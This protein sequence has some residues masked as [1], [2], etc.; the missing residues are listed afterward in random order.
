MSVIAAYVYRNGQRVREASVSDDLPLEPG[1]FVWIGLFEPDEPEL[2]RLQERF[3]LHPLAV[4]DAL[5]AHQRPKV[6]VYGSELFVVARTAELENDSIVSGETHCF[7]GERYVISVRHGSAR[8]HSGLRT[9]LEASPV[10]LRHGPDY[11]LHAILD[12]IVDGYLPIVDTVEER[13]IAMEHRALEAF[14]TR[15]DISALFH[16]RRELALFQ[17][18]LDPMEEV[19]GR[20]KR[21]D[22]PCIDA[23]TRPY[24]RDVLDH[25]KRV[26]GRVSALRDALGAVFELGN[27][28]EQQ[29]QGAITRQLAA[30]AAIL[31]VPTAVGWRYGYFAVLG[32]IGALCISLYVRFKRLGWL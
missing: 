21:L 7:V 18:V 16:L 11:V 25:V 1:E 9:Q 19:C 23:E 15:A 31:A 12:F 10:L 8:A 26:G 29:R 28:L 22:L 4:E 2:R 20:L 32:V 14:L 24:F 5:S 3:G 17:R 6:E 27:L 30:W 13:V